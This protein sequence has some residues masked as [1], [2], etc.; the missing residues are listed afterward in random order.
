MHLKCLDRGFFVDQETVRSLLHIMDPEGVE[1]RRKRRVYSVIGH[2]SVWHID[3]YDKL[4]RYGI[5]FLF[6]YLF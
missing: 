2:N 1:Y 4:S 6:V 5:M 3:G